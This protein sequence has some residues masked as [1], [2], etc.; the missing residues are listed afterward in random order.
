MSIYVHAELFTVHATN[1][2]K[3]I[4]ATKMC[5]YSAEKTISLN[6]LH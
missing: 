3:Q 6:Y 2:Y 1:L 5:A 4:V